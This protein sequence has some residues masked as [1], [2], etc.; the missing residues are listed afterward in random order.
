LH[1]EKCVVHKSDVHILIIVTFSLHRFR[2]EELKERKQASFSWLESRSSVLVAVF[3][4]SENPKILEEMEAAKRE[5]K[6]RKRMR[7]G[8][9][10]EE[11]ELTCEDKI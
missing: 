11:E 3:A 4:E 5:L 9:C 8:K 1:N 7:D 2:L 10:I 6:Y